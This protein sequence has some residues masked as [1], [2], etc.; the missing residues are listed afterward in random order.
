MKRSLYDNKEERDQD[1]MLANIS[2]FFRLFET[3]PGRFSPVLNSEEDARLIMEVRA[4]AAARLVI[5]MVMR[6]SAS[7]GRLT[8]DDL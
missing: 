4:F 6:S 3:H 8:I 2:P 5:D 7:G 1:V